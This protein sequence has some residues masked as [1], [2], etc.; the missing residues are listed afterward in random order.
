VLIS[1]A[2]FLPVLA[3]SRN[4]IPFVLFLGLPGVAAAVAGAVLGRSLVAPSRFRTA[5]WAAFRGAAI[6]TV[7]LVLFAP[8]FAAVI[9]WTERGWTSVAGLTVMVLWFTFI[10]AWPLAAAIGAAVGLALYRWAVRTRRE[11]F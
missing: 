6:A 10:A 7:A 4:P 5:W 1:A 9:K 11:A 3:R 2:W 8:M